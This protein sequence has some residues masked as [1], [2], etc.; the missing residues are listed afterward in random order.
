MLGVDPVEQV[1][2]LSQFTI[3]NYETTWGCGK[4]GFMLQ[5]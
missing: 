5:D 4:L 1:T 3:L 2:D